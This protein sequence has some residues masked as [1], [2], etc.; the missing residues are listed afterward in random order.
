MRRQ[1]CHGISTHVGMCLCSKPFSTANLETAAEKA[2]TKL[3]A[4]HIYVFS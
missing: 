3:R 2:V 1:I 4:A